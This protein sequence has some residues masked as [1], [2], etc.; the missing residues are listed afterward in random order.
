[1]SKYHSKKITFNG[2]K[3]DSKKEFQRWQELRL[4]EKVGAIQNLR[5]QVKF[6]LIPT[7]RGPDITGPH[8]GEKAGKVIEY[9]ICYIADFVYQRDGKQVVE[10]VKGV[11]T[12]AYIMKRKL[13]LWIHG[14]RILET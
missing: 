9:P 11:K 12:D 5:R 10:D 1:M 6:E 4:L 3:F 2:E 7:Q 8:G 13:M 14:I